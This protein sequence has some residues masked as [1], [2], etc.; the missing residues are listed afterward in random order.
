VK[1]DIDT[2][3]ISFGG[4]VQQ[5]TASE[6]RFTGDWVRANGDKRLDDA[7]CA[8]LADGFSRVY[9]RA[10]RAG[11]A[12]SVC[13]HSM[14]RTVFFDPQPWP[15]ESGRRLWARPL[16]LLSTTICVEMNATQPING[17][18]FGYTPDGP[19]VKLLRKVIPLLITGEHPTA[20]AITRE[21]RRQRPS[22]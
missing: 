11:A 6:P 12:P 2:D 20:A 4:L 14:G 3:S 13:I 16:R 22:G 8:R 7:A 9:A 5:P 1:I 18:P 10:E 21:L 15:V 17:R 19:V